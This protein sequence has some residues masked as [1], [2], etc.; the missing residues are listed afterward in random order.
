VPTLVK[1]LQVKVRVLIFFVY[2]KQNFIPF[3]GTSTYFI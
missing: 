3:Y 1:S 2:E